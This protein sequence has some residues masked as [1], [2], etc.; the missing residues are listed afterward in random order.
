MDFRAPIPEW[1]LILVA[2]MPQLVADAADRLAAGPAGGEVVQP[3][4]LD[5]VPVGLMPIEEAQES[6]D[7]GVLLVAA[8]Q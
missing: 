4:P 3:V 2:L 6:V 8:S 7:H 5:A 1:G